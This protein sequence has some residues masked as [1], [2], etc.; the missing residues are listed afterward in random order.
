M[1]KTPMEEY[2]VM[3]LMEGIIGQVIVMDVFITK[4]DRVNL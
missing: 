2:G 4:K 1:T 3:D